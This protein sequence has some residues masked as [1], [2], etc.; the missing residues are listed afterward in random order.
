MLGNDKYGQSTPVN[1]F[2]DAVSAGYLH[3]CGILKSGFVECW[4]DDK[5]GQSTP[6][7]G[8]FDAVS[9]GYLHTCGLFAGSVECWGYGYDRYGQSTPSDGEFTAVSVGGAGRT[10]GIRDHYDFEGDEVECWGNYMFDQSTPPE[11]YTAPIDG[12][13]A[14]TDHLDHKSPSIRV[15]LGGAFAIAPN[16]TQETIVYAKLSLFIGQVPSEQYTAPIDGEKACT[17]HLDHK[18]PSIRVGLGG[19]FA[20]AP[21]PT[22]E[23]IVYAKLSLFIGQVPSEQDIALIEGEKA[24]IDHLDNEDWTIGYYA[25]G[26]CVEYTV[27]GLEHQP[28]SQPPVYNIYNTYLWV[29]ES[30]RFDADI[31]IVRFPP[32]AP[33]IPLE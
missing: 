27:I 7:N 23:T 8:F 15:G 6:V 5:Y 22:Q 14:C 4:G 12:E 16:P 28:S 18:S 32:E 13:K 10:C 21:N 30:A 17:D 33:G 19:A 2:F 9:A 31:P 26:G 20:I 11:Q 3:T 29:G 24:R 1:G 25:D